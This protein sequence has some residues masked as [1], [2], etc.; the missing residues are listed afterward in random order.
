VHPLSS[1]L[2]DAIWPNGVVEPFSFTSANRSHALENC[3]VVGERY[4]FDS[5]FPS[6]DRVRTRKEK[7][8]PDRFLGVQ[9][10]RER[11]GI[12]LL[13][14]LSSRFRRCADDVGSVAP[15]HPESVPEMARGVDGKKDK[16]ARRGSQ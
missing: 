8:Y 11:T 12:K 16:K 10:T 5:L 7:H 3:G 1:P 9:R 4:F 13:C 14:H 2:F 15:V 6:V